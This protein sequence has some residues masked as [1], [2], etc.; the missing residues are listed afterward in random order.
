MEKSKK[1]VLRETNKNEIIFFFDKIKY[2]KMTLS[3]I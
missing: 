1:K 3:L 2:K